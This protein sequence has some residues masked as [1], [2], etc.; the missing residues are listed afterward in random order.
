MEAALELLLSLP[1]WLVYSGIGLGTALENVFP[2]VPSDTFVLV[3][4]VLADRG[5][6]LNAVVI[7][8]SAWLC[9]V[10]GAMWVFSAA[11]RK[12]PAAFRGRFG[13]RL[14]RRH[15]FAQV[16]KF[17]DKYGMAAVFVSRFLPVLRVIVPAFA[18]FTGISPVRTLVTVSVASL[19]W[20]TGMVIAGTLASQNVEPV[21]AA[22]QRTNTSLL[23]VAGVLAAALAWWWFRTR[24]RSGGPRSGVR[25]SS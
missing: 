19:L 18:G 6:T 8:L 23:V 3:G 24:R 16:Q 9:N 4:A 17:Y 1:S 5:S 20:M 21:V 2:P 15:Q 13:R 12:G 7:V 11:R 10:A 22:L 25:E 14:L